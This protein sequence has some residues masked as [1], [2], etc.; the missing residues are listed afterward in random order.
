MRRQN[1]CIS[2]SD[3]TLQQSWLQS[4]HYYRSELKARLRKYHTY[5]DKKNLNKKELSEETERHTNIARKQKE[6]VVNLLSDA[7]ILEHSKLRYLL[8]IQQDLSKYSREIRDLSMCTYES[9]FRL[10]LEKCEYYR[11]KISNDINY[12]KEN[13]IKV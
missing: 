10:C 8:D 4:V 11:K 6:V 12:Y 5:Q 9:D 1:H 3:R 7:D 13:Y 2:E